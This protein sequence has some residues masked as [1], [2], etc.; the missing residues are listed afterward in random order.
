MPTNPII[1]QIGLKTDEDPRELNKII[2]KGNSPSG[3]NPITDK[4]AKSN[5]MEA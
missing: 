1:N 4:K 2:L 3:G 5:P